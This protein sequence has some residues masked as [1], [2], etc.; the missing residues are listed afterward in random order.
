[1]L[2]ARVGQHVNFSLAFLDAQ[3]QPMQ[4]TPTPD[5]PP[6]WNN[7]KLDR[8]IAAPDGLTCQADTVGP[9]TDTIT[10]QVTVAGRSYT[11]TLQAQVNP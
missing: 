7:L 1:M 3:G 4:T 11:G 5:A 2:T 6:T 8:L 10:V 9:G